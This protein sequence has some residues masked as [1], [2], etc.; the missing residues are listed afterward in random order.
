MATSIGPPPADHPGLPVAAAVAVVV[1]AAAVVA[2]T[3]PHAV[4]AE[5]EDLRIPMAGTTPTDLRIHPLPLNALA[6]SNATRSRTSLSTLYPKLVG[7]RNGR[8]RFT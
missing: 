8:T 3:V 6:D 7:S 4:R 5:G 1:A 2:M